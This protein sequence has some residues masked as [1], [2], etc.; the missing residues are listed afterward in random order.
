MDDFPAFMKSNTNAISQESQSRGVN[1]WFYESVDGKQM[2]YWICEADGVSEEHIHEFDEYFTVV[3]GTYVLMMGNEKIVL[4]KGDEYFIP[5][6]VPH[7]G[8]FVAGMRT[9]HCFGGTRVVNA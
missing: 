4:Q 5:R 3:Q 6:G 7:W 2:A 1:G 8:E 9:I